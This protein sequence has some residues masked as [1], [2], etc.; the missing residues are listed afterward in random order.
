M[1]PFVQG[2]DNINITDEKDT[3]HRFD[4]SNPPLL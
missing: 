3:V 2:N 4:N 1:C